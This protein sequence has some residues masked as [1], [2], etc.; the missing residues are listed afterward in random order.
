M[1]TDDTTV[2]I[3]QEVAEVGEIYADD[4]ISDFEDDSENKFP[5]FE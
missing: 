1:K 2:K 5:L 4:D 3:L